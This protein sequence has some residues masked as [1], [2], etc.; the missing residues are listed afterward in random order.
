LA[1][2]PEGCDQK[3]TDWRVRPVRCRFVAGRKTFRVGKIKR[4]VGEP[5]S[6]AGTKAADLELARLI[7]EVDFDSL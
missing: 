6:T 4:T 7:V 2:L 5:N 1:Y 3:P